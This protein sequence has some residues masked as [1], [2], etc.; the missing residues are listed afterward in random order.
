MSNYPVH[1]KLKEVQPI[2]QAIHEFIFWLDETKQIELAAREF[3]RTR[4][5]PTTEK[6]TDLVAQ[7]LGIDRRKLEDEK[8]QML[9]EMR[10]ANEPKNSGD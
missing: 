3:G 4:L 10:K 5:L 8:V 9:E 7:Y 2:S 1:E 6:L